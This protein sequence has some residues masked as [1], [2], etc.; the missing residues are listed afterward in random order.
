M[1]VA[2]QLVR[3]FVEVDDFWKQLDNYEYK[4]RLLPSPAAQ[5]PRGPR[6]R[7]SDSEIMTIL[8]VFQKVRFPDFKAFYVF[9][10][11]Y[12]AEYFPG[13]P[14]Y[15]RF[16]E[17]MRRV[18]FPLTIFPQLN[19]RKEPVFIISILPVSPSVISNAVKDTKRLNPSP[20]TEKPPLAGFLA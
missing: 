9:I 19:A 17:L 7:L 4:G 18:I 5:K 1:E 20:P 2:H 8:L 11:Q 3:I 10:A 15:N 16:I 6:C 12:Y 13:L 14:S